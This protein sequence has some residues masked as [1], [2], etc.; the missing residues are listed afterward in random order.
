MSDCSKRTMRGLTNLGKKLADLRKCEIGCGS[1][2]CCEC[3]KVCACVTM[4]VCIKLQSLHGSSP[5]GQRSGG[6]RFLHPL[7]ES[8]VSCS[9]V[10]V[11]AGGTVPSLLEHSSH[12][13]V[14]PYFPRAV[15]TGLWLLNA[16]DRFDLA[17]ARS[18]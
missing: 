4:W 6:L 10:T 14:P 17:C 5:A 15:A 12:H 9:T 13:R 8:L 2:T 11:G 16:A 3:F 7:R 1:G 18:S